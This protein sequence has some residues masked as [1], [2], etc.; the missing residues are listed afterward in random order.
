[1]RHY[2]FLQTFESGAPTSSH[3]FA[4]VSAVRFG[5]LLRSRTLTDSSSGSGT[6]LREPLL[7]SVGRRCPLLLGFQ[8]PSSE[9]LFSASLF[10]LF[11]LIVALVHCQATGR[12]TTTPT[13]PTTPR[14]LAYG[15]LGPSARP[16]A[17]GPREP[18]P[19]SAPHSV[20]ISSLCRPHPDRIGQNEQ[21]TRLG[22][23][24]NKGLPLLE[25]KSNSVTPQKEMVTCNQM[26]RAQK[27]KLAF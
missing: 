8:S 21:D 5:P 18:A 1:M 22:R 27:D 13:T 7:F 25:M 16:G 9:L 12:S 24:K 6:S 17:R 15:A 4:G 23:G 11:G 2:T 26:T 3:R 19:D 14:R 10:D 20:L